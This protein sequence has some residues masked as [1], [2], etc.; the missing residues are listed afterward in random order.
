MKPRYEARPTTTA[1][2]R[3]TIV[4]RVFDNE[5]QKFTPFGIHATMA[6]AEAAAKRL[7]RR[8]K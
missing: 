3:S 2:D 8:K 4:Y 1:K 6:K 5:T 7:N